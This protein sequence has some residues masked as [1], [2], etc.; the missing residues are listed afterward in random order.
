VM[1]AVVTNLVADTFMNLLQDL[2]PD[3]K[4]ELAPNLIT[5]L[6]NTWYRICYQYYVISGTKSGTR[7]DTKSGTGF[8]TTSGSRC[9]LVLGFFLCATTTLQACGP[10]SEER[11]PWLRPQ[12]HPVGSRNGH[13]RALV[14]FHHTRGNW[15]GANYLSQRTQLVAHHLPPRQGPTHLQ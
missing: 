13:L 9:K 5:N 12:T 2:V 8:E 7:F 15:G 3:L 14:A 4:P 1:S 6:L 11:A 10:G